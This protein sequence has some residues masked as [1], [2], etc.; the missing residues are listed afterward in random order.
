[1]KLLIVIVNYRT[2]SLVIDCLGSLDPEVAALPGTRVV[3]TDNASGDDSVPLLERTI[4]DRG[5][6]AW[7][8][9]MPLAR[10]GGFA[11]GNNAAI[12][13]ALASA[14]PPDYVLLLNP[15]TLVRPGAVRTLVGFLDAH[16]EAEIVGPRLEG[17][18]GTL[19]CSVFR[20]PSVLG[21]LEQGLRLGLATRLLSKWVVAPPPPSVARSTDWV[22]GACLMA[23]RSVLERV[24]LLDEGYFM[25]YE[26]VDFC[27]R[28]ARAGFSC[29]YEPAARVVHLE[30]STQGVRGQRATSARRPG[31][32]FDSRRRYFR[33]HLGP[34]RGRL[35]DLAWVLGYA[36]YRVRRVVQRKP[37]TDPPGLLIDLVRRNLLT[38]GGLP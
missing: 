26:E 31:F 24:G 28:A 17:P 5:W 15:D 16:S 1:M 14:D 30:G 10:N 36:S 2:A 38:G 29:W 23:R 11:F 33:T 12:R 18:D 32:W 8:E 22:S 7:A 19:Q 3:V 4:R 27:R 37:E 34:V 13:P 9:L 21:E 35:A 25:Y 6:G 20:F